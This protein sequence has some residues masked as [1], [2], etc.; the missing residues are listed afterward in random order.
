[1][2][3]FEIYSIFSH[4][5]KKV[6]NINFLTFFKCTGVKLEYNKIIIRKSK[7]LNTL[8]LLSL[9]KIS[10]LL[11]KS[12]LF[13]KMFLWFEKSICNLF[14]FVGNSLIRCTLSISIFYSVLIKLYLLHCFMNI[15]NICNV[16]LVPSYIVYIVTCSNNLKTRILV[17][18][19]SYY[20]SSSPSSS[21]LFANHIFQLSNIS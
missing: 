18:S 20:Y 16:S 12:S 9:S 6:F 4:Q 1:M 14:Y 8:Q 3:L 19:T 11:F 21:F 10:L 2:Q 5:S 7:L 13:S 15:L 17:I